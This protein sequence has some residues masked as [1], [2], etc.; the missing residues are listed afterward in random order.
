MDL[1]DFVPVAVD[2]D[3]SV[4][5]FGKA[6]PAHKPDIPRS[7]DC[8][9]HFSL[10]PT[11]DTARKGLPDLDVSARNTA[12]MVRAFVEV[13]Q[14]RQAICVC[15][16]NGVWGGSPGTRGIVGASSRLES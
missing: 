11:K 10:S 1:L 16:S 12:S 8:D 14:T 13:L 7:Y 6:G 9:M 4:S 2:T 3:N 15:E 5:E